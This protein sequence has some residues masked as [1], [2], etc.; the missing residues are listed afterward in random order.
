ME[1]EN[2]LYN[3][4]EIEI[5]IEAPNGTV[6]RKSAIEEIKKKHS[7]GEIVIKTIEQKFG[8]KKATVTA[9][10]YASKED[11]QKSEPAWIF[12]RGQPKEQKKEG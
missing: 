4:K 3:R 2:K 1:K 10:V 5:E 11:A 8:R 12:K 9:F 7:S 6:S